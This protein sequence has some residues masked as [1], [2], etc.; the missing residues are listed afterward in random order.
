MHKPLFTTPI[1]NTHRLVAGVLLALTGVDLATV[2]L[3]VLRPR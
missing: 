3:D 2:A 1:R